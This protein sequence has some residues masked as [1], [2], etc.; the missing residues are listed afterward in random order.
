MTVLRP[1]GMHG[2]CGGR[3]GGEGLRR[4]GGSTEE[5]RA[6]HFLVWKGQRSPIERGFLL[7][8]ES[9]R[10][11]CGTTPPVD[12]TRPAV[13]LAPPAEGLGAPPGAGDDCRGHG[14]GQGGRPCERLGEEGGSH[15]L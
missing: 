1:R 8:S 2:L 14:A 13:S 10:G 15:R 6:L 4:V 7:L 9:T 3:G 11:E 5:G 12:V